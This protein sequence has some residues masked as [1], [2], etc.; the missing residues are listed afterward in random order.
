MSRISNE[1]FEG[2]SLYTEA[3]QS[4]MN[5][6]YLENEICLQIILLE[7]EDLNT[8]LRNVEQRS[9]AAEVTAIVKN[10]IV[11][12][13]TLRSYLLPLLFILPA[14]TRFEDIKNDIKQYLDIL[15]K[16]MKLINLNIDNRY[17]TFQRTY[18]D[19]KYN[20]FE[21]LYGKV[22]PILKEES[23][24]NNNPLFDVDSDSFVKDV[25]GDDDDE[26]AGAAPPEPKP[27]RKPPK[28]SGKLDDRG[29]NRRRS[30]AQGRSEGARAVALAKAKAQAEA[31]EREA[32]EFIARF[33]RLDAK[34]AKKGLIKLTL[35]SLA[36]DLRDNPTKYGFTDENID[37]AKDLVNI[38]YN[39]IMSDSE[40]SEIL[41]DTYG[42]GFM[43]INTPKI[44]NLPAAAGGGW[45]DAD[46]VAHDGKMDYYD[47]LDNVFLLLDKDYR[48]YSPIHKIYLGMI[49]W[50]FING[51]FNE[52]K[53]EPIIDYNPAQRSVYEVLIAAATSVLDDKINDN[54]PFA[55]LGVAR[56]GSTPRGVMRTESAARPATPAPGF[57]GTT[58][59]RKNLKKKKKSTK[60]NKKRK[61]YKKSK[62][63]LKLMKK[64]IKVKN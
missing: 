19:N 54:N 40:Y 51:E 25:T 26:M 20:E 14:G 16:T 47:I 4:I 18:S 1:L 17:E 48:D 24:M 28:S 46:G 63:K 37:I 27:E 56:S 33:E 12:R 49:E 30:E 64:T 13:D 58:K 34:A 50:K 43:T 10:A 38:W 6:Y 7:E 23:E 57:G 61:N 9:D 22:N 62:R 35:E 3:M 44:P 45:R 8:Y 31:R 53:I 11:L 29:L 36:P 55:P 41:I 39:V 21:D 15:I 59:K 2:T 52:L 60:A 42:I 5:N 32:A